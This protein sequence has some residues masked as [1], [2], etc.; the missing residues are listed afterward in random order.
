MKHFA[1]LFLVALFMGAPMRLSAEL[2]GRYSDNTHYWYHT[3][4]GHGVRAPAEGYSY[5]KRGGRIVLDFWHEDIMGAPY[6]GDDVINA[7]ESLS[8]G[9]REKMRGEVTAWSKEMRILAKATRFVGN[10]FWKDGKECNPAQW[11]AAIKA[12][13]EAIDANP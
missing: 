13:T 2:T 12:A 1:L 5:I 9:I 10:N 4:Q 11:R 3:D 6:P 7:Q 8:A